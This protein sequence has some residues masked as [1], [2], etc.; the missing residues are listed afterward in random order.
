MAITS[1]SDLAHSDNTKLYSSAR[2]I[3]EKMDSPIDLK[4]H[5]FQ[6]IKVYFVDSNLAIGDDAVG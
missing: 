5:N 1:E 3:R 6:F 4:N 2:L